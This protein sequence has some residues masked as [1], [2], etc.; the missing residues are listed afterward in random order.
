VIA[1][2]DEFATDTSLKYT[3]DYILATPA[4]NGAIWSTAQ[5][6]P[7]NYGINDTYYTDPTQ[8][9]FGGYN[10]YSLTD[11]ALNITAEPVPA[12]YA[13]APALTFGGYLHHWLSGQLYS[14]PLTYGYVEVAA[15]EPNLQGF[16]PAP[17]WLVTT[18]YSA[19]NDGPPNLVELDANE[20]FGGG[21]LVRQTI[22]YGY[23]TSIAGES[24]QTSQIVN[25]DPSLVYHTYGILWTATN[26]Q[27]FIDRV[28]TSPAYPTVS[29]GP[30]NAMI[31]LAVYAAGAYAP[32]PLTQT[33]QTMSLQ[34]YRWYQAT[35]TSCSPT[36]IS[37]S[38]A[39]R[40]EPT[41]T[42]SR[43]SRTTA[44]R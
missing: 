10:P 9:Y 14:A 5:H 31:D 7:F 1:Q 27:F 34:Y 36:I 4:P 30:M 33:P 40:T 32:P 19:V 42:M 38:I 44:H 41:A 29:T 15:K 6:Q 26:A 35:G 2:D 24:L 13:T 17:L 11:N 23:N 28:A 20:I 3:P 22:H 18:N 39:H 37:S 25:P 43:R 12:P 21:S 16:W 8:T